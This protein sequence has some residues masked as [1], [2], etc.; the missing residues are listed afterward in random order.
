MQINY[1]AALLAISFVVTSPI[2]FGAN[3]D[4]LIKLDAQR[5]D[6]SQTNY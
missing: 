6:H 1:K 2:A 5:N 4:R 3:E